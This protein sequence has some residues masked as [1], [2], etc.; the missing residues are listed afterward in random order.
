[1]Q[2]CYWQSEYH[3][4]ILLLWTK[5]TEYQWWCLELGVVIKSSIQVKYKSSFSVLAQILNTVLWSFTLRNILKEKEDWIKPKFSNI[6]A[7][8]YMNGKNVSNRKIYKYSCLI[9]SS[10]NQPLLV[11]LFYL[12][13]IFASSRWND[14]KNNSHS[15][16]TENGSW[17][18]SKKY[19]WSEKQNY[20]KPTE[21]CEIFLVSCA[22]SLLNVAHT[23]Q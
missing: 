22:H 18:L 6:L 17:S 15:L 23:K 12:I 3:I 10:N 8:T 11:F 4:K 7:Q 5:N 13:E 19:I 14:N 9:P 20:S 21:F 16:K 1:M 2:W